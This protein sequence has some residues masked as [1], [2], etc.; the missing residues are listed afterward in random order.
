MSSNDYTQPTASY[1]T[2]PLPQA[3][4]PQ[5]YLAQPQDPQQ[6]QQPQ[7]QYASPVPVGTTVASTNTYALISIILAFVAPP[8]AIVFGHLG[9][10][11]IKRTGDAG[12]GLALTGTIIGYAYFALIALLIIFY[13]GMIVIMF[14]AMGAA[15]SELDSYNYSY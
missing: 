7:P 4:E 3:T 10:S 2:E 12:R 5:P 11:Q 9:L 6:A 13:I 15:F 1:P 14:G 8:V